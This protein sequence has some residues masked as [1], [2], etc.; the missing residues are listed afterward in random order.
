MRERAPGAGEP[1][2]GFLYYRN[3]FL[4][5]YFLG[6]KMADFDL[7]QRGRGVSASKHAKISEKSHFPNFFGR[8]VLKSHIPAK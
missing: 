6:T 4:T 5:F 8:N 1:R 2:L 7:F 3:I